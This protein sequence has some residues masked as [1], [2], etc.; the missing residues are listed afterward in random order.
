VPLAESALLIQFDD[1]GTVDR[2]LVEE[3]SA[4]AMAVERAAIPGV[5]DIVPAYTTILVSF[6]PRETEPMTL[7]PRIEQAAAT[8]QGAQATSR[9]VTIPVIYGG[10]Y[11][12]DL[13]DVA[14]FTGLS[15]EEVIARHTAAEY[16]VACIGFSPGFPY[17]LGLPPALATPRLPNPRTRV[18]AGSVGIGGEQTGVYPQ[19]TPG[20]W[21]LIGRTPLRL[22]DPEG[23]EPFLLR[24]GDHLRF[25]AIST[26][27]FIALA[28][29]SSPDETR[30]G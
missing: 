26:A 2:A 11:G 20:G 22:F 16:L 4:L 15:A 14:A 28:A 5:I 3:V 9:E 23:E 24:A 18:P 30:R 7:M 10:E 25:T 21:R 17:L 27:E 13:D 8:R 12:P 1:G 29:Q 6:D 19:A